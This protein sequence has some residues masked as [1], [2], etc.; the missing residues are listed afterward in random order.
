MLGNTLQSTG[1]KP[2]RQYI[3]LQ[4]TQCKVPKPRVDLVGD[5]IHFKTFLLYTY[6]S[7][8]MAQVH[9]TSHVFTDI[10]LPRSFAEVQTWSVHT[11][12][13]SNAT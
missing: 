3:C 11:S 8:K 2:V 13:E 4:T 1:Y 6:P 10:E 7:P 9:N 12:V 5:I